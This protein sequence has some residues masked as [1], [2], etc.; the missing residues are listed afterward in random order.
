MKSIIT[1]LV[2]ITAVYLSAQKPVLL[3]DINPAGNSNPAYF[4]C[5]GNGKTVFTATDNVN[6][7]ELWI[8]D[9][10][11]TGTRLVKDI[12]SGIQ[13]SNPSE[14]IQLNGKVLFKASNASNGTELWI[15]DGTNAGTTLLKEFRAGMDSTDIKMLTVYNNKVYLYA[16]GSNNGLWSTDGSTSGTVFVKDIVVGSNYSIDEPIVYNGKLYFTVSW[17]TI[18][19]NDFSE[20]WTTDGTASGTEQLSYLSVSG[21]GGEPKSYYI[22]DNRLFFQA[23]YFDNELYV[24]NGTTAGTQLFAD[25]RVGGHSNPTGFQSYF[26][27]LLFSATNGLDGIELFSSDGTAAGTGMMFDKN[28][29]G[30]FDPKF[31]T[32]FKNKV[33]FQAK[34]GTDIELWVYDAITNTANLFKNIHPS[35]SSEPREFFIM[36]H[37]DKLYFVATT[38]NGNRF[39]ETDGTVANTIEVTPLISNNFSH[40]PTLK[41]GKYVF[42]ECDGMLLYAA[43]YTSV[44][45]EPYVIGTNITSTEETAQ[46]LSA[47]ALYPNPLSSNQ[48]TIV[49]Q[50]EYDVQIIDI[51]GKVIFKNH[52]S[53]GENS[54]ELPA[55]QNGVYFVNVGNSVQ[56]LVKL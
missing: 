47:F 51:Q 22:F 39:F 2:C 12:Y 27:S 25:L 17:T 15:T 3:K 28:T 56:K 30:D 6:G 48:F 53:A 5:L 46:E 7:R 38:P 26:G 54:I 14:L 44:G 36:N 55:I 20:L 4:T 50:K 41:Q 45:E 40:V 35:S 33:F 32:V 31:L 8:T 18:T 34:L 9:G 23:N 42:K 10:T 11:T 52:L 29:S 37:F 13:S 16:N 19:L 24:T 43:N 21:R 49:I 1:L